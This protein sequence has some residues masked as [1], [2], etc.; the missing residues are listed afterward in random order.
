MKEL[1]TNLTA[2]VKTRFGPSRKITRHNGGKQGSRLMGR[3]FS[4]QMDTISENFISQDNLNI[5]VNSKLSIGALVWVDD[6]LSCTLGIRNQRS[7]LETVDDFARRNK[8]EWGESKCKV[9][10]VGK[11]VKVPEK[12]QLGEKNISNTTSYKYLG[13]TITNDGKNKTNLELKEN[14]I[15]ATIRQINTTA[16]SDVMRGVESKVL[17]ILFQKCIETSLINNSESW[18]LSKTEEQQL[19]KIGIKAMK[20]LFNLPTTTPSAAIIHSFGI[21]YM[22][23]SVDT[24]RF[25][26]LHK[27]LN[28]EDEQHWTKIMLNHLNSLQMGWARSLNDK[29]AQYQLETDWGKIRLKSKMEWKRDVEKA[30][31]KVNKEKIMSNC[32]S[33]TPQGTKINTKTKYTHHQIT[34][35]EGEYKREPLKEV[36]QGDRQRSK[37]L[38]LARHG[39]LE[40]GAN[41]KG[42]MLEK[43]RECNVTDNEYHRLN[44]CTKWKDL[45]QADSPEKFVFENIY[46]NDADIL[47]LIIGAIENVWEFRY[48]NGRMKKSLL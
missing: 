45:N 44:E 32:T 35:N 28:R 1:S 8:L 25:M 11:K 24:K 21:L 6:V 18:T 36:I 22:T 4:K 39:M 20:R 38:I 30:V 26:Y 12:W 10:Q 48:A 27:V 42:T 31:D 3:L 40:C 9:M 34:N 33:E 15:Q 37:T 14:K 5:K 19:D 13:D 23:Q 43:C 2:V 46:S 47:K 16:S 17:L 29:L 7:V 41:F